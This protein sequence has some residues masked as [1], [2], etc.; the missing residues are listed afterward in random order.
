MATLIDSSVFIAVERQ[1]LDLE[2]AL[3]S[4]PDEDFAIAAITVS[5]L[6][7]GVHRATKPEVQGRRQAFVENVVSVF[8]VYPFDLST[9][10]VHSRVWAEL[11]KRGRSV[12]AHDLLIAATAIAIG[13]QVATRNTKDFAQIPGLTI[14]RW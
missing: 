10:R 1:Q 2:R 7:H 6:L 13:G 14:L 11:A 8:R 12:G 9:A 3:A 5:E 4:Y